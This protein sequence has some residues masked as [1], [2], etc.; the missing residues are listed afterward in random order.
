M[1][2]TE[3]GPYQLEPPRAFTAC[4]AVTLGDTWDGCLPDPEKIVMKLHANSGHASPQQ[5]K[6]VSADTD[7]D[8]AHSIIFADAVL[9]KR[10]VRRAFDKA[11]RVPIA[12]PPW[13]PCLMGNRRGAFSAWAI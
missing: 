3:D 9:G 11:P 2:Y 4:E 10:E 13:C 5:L 12:G 1:S 8:N 6:K 7:G